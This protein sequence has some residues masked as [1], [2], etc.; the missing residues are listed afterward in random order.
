M[1]GVA[2]AGAG[3]GGVTV[4]IRSATIA[5]AADLSTRSVTIWKR[6]VRAFVAV[7]AAR[8]AARVG[9]ALP[10][11]L[12]LLAVAAPVQGVAIFATA[13]ATAAAIVAR[14]RRRRALAMLAAPALAA[15]ALAT[16]AT[17][18]HVPS[19]G[20]LIAAAGVAGLVAVAV[21]TWLVHR[22]PDG[23]PGAR[24]RCARVPRPGVGQRLGGE[25]PAAP[26][27]RDRGRHAGVRVALAA[28]RDATMTTSH[29]RRSCCGG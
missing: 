9:A 16:L 12:D 6:I 26:V 27:R 19:I 4:A 1:I 7:G 29:R 2:A 20:P 15:V 21:L 28:R 14:D 13:S 17:R 18:V 5:V 22:R 3:L 25:P 24:G 11:S 10:A 8:G 23:A